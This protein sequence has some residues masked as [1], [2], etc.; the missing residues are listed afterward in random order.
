MA[1]NSLKAQSELEQNITKH[2]KVSLLPLHLCILI[3]SGESS[4]VTDIN[5]LHAYLQEACTFIQ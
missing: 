3:F 4:E 2:V 1:D 5:V